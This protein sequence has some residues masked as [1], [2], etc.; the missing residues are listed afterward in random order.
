MYFHLSGKN[1]TMF[2]NLMDNNTARI[3]S[4]NYTMYYG[5]STFRAEGIDFWETIQLLYTA[6]LP[7]MNSN[8]S[9]FVATMFWAVTLFM[10]F[11][12]ISRIVPFIG[13]G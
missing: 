7:G 11:T 10:L 8:I 6:K 3:W 2:F 12:M 5:W 9:F 4:S 1:D 13:G